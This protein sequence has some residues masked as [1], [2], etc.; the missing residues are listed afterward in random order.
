MVAGCGGDGPGAAAE[1]EAPVGQPLLPD[2]MPKPQ[3]NVLVKE[4]AG[5]WVIRFTTTLVNV[6]RGDFI[7]RAK[8]DARGQWVAEQDVQYSEQGAKRLPVRAALVWGG[9]G[10]DHWHIVRVASVW[11]APLADAAAAAGVTD[12]SLVDSKIGF[13]FYDHTHELD[14]G[15]EKARYSAH[16]CGDKKDTII[17]M[18]LSP[19][20]NDI[21]TMKLP[22]QSIDITDVPPGE[23]RLYTRVD[24]Q[25]WFREANRRNNVTWLDLEI[26][27]R[28][29]AISVASL[30]RG[31]SP[32]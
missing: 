18:G 11:L 14:R 8:R 2:L 32:R 3:F 22:G 29:G 31:P 12:T 15:P 25:G 28:N 24:E 21:Y 10:H 1:P 30:G 7:L 19:G 23:Y 20:W 6:G 17:G 5:R 4:E 16:S 26:T 13:C 27:E 9:D